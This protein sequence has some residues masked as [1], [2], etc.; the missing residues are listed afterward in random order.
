M[1]SP[2]AV[3]VTKVDVYFRCRPFRSLAQ[4]L[5][6]ATEEGA[7]LIFDPKSG[8]ASRSRYRPAPM[9]CSVGVPVHG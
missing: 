1:L 8:G 7:Q 4:T 5:F 9:C 2:E 3:H 6:G